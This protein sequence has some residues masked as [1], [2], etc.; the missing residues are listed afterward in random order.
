MNPGQENFFNFILESVR[1]GKQEEVKALLNKSIAEQANG[2]FTGEFLKGFYS[3]IMSFN[4][5]YRLKVI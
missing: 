5:T 2:T 3:K 4:N 1:N